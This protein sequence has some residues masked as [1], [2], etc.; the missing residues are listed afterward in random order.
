MQQSKQKFIVIVDEHTA[1]NFLAVGFKLISKNG[2]TYTFLN[3]PPK[4]F[5]FEQFDKTKV[6]YTNMLSI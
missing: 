3:Q 4:N 5:N 1:K 2:G 6:Y